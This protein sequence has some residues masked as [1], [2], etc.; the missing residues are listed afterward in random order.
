MFQ[1]W[2]KP[3]LHYSCIKKKQDKKNAANYR[4]N[5]IALIKKIFL[6]SRITKII[7]SL[8]PMED[9]FKYN[10]SIIIVI[11]IISYEI[12]RIANPTIHMLHRFK[13]FDRIRLPNIK[14]AK[15]KIEEN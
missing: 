15:R 2:E 11:Y 12:N 14:K 10:G 4:N 13:T 7:C 5:A 9:Y 6:T 8:V 1:T 3:I